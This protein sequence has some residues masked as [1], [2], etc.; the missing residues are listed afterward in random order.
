MLATPMLATIANAVWLRLLMLVG[1]ILLV[2]VQLA[3]FEGREVEHLPPRDPRR[4]LASA[5]LIGVPPI[6]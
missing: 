1:A 6:K 5:S 4:M 2:G 3:L